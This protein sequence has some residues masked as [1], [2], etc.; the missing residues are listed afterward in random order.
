LICCVEFGH[1]VSATSSVLLQTS[2]FND[3]DRRAAGVLLF[4][5]RRFLKKFNVSLQMTDWE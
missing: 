3:G 5:W 1:E 4:A 2:F